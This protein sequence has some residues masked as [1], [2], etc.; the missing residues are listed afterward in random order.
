MSERAIELPL[1]MR[2]AA[3]VSLPIDPGPWIAGFVVFALMLFLPQILDD[4]DTYW[5]VRTGLWIMEHGEIPHVDPFSFTAG[6]RHWFPHEWL[7]ET[8][9]GLFYRLG[10]MRGVMVLAATTTGLTA[11]I[12]FH[13]FRRFVPGAC[14]AILL[15]V[16]LSNSMLSLLARPHLL[17]WPCL[18]LWVAGLVTARARREAPSFWLLPAMVLWVNLHGSFIL[19]LLL[20][21]AF[22][23][24]ALFDPGARPRQV[25]VSWSA[26][27]LASV[28]AAMVNPEGPG[29]LLFPFQLLGMSNLASIGEWRAIDFSH[30]QPMELL[31]AAGLVFGFSPGFAGKVRIPPMRL[32]MLMGLIHG[33][34]AHGRHGQLLGLIGTLILAEPIGAAIAPVASARLPRWLAP[35]CAI[36]VAAALTVRVARPLDP[37]HSGEAFAAVLDRVPAA[38]RARN[39]LNDYSYG[40]ALIFHGVRPY[41]DSRADLYGDVFLD[42]YWKATQTERGLLEQALRDHAIGWTIFPA[43]H[44]IVRMLD[45]EPGWR[46]L[47]QAGKVVIHVREGLERQD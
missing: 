28:F 21:G 4:G 26:F 42:A 35:A 12:L 37:D 13:G 31:V 39:V 6:D 29:G 10:G 5:Q 40:G 45:T 9:M 33:A 1:A 30:A 44:G 27:M 20:P 19:G 18:T 24:E 38:T 43:T 23:I 14:A 8:L 41:V 16:A 34:L 11:A 15:S 46:R 2:G 36:L 32:L 17:A 22:M 25:F 7:A 47:T 3:T